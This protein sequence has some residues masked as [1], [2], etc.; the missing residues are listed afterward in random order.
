MGLVMGCSWICE[1]DA[2]FIGGVLGEGDGFADC[3]FR[4]VDTGD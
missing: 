3:V 1:F 2:F 4:E